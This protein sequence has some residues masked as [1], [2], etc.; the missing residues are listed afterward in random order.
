M[1][2][3]LVLF[4]AY[5]TWYF[6]SSTDI[7]AHQSWLYPF[8]QK[9]LPTSVL[10]GLWSCQMRKSP[11][12]VALSLYAQNAPSCAEKRSPALWLICSA[13]CCSCWWGLT[14]FLNCSHQWTSC[15]VHP[16]GDTQVWENR[17]PGGGGN[18]SQCHIVHHK[19]HMD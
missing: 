4:S 6:Y 1:A 3:P 11:T 18:L 16:P 12:S 14:M 15:S 17:R 8:T 5:T 10:Q 9:L 19:S 13:L 2:A 7:F